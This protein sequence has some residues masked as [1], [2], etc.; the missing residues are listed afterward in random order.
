MLKS[1][2]RIP[3]VRSRL[4][5]V[6]SPVGDRDRLSGGNTHLDLLADFDPDLAQIAGAV[7]VFDRAAHKLEGLIDRHAGRHQLAQDGMGGLL[8]IRRHAVQLSVRFPLGG[9]C[10]VS[11]QESN[12]MDS[13]SPNRHLSAKLELL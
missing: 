3:G 5:C 9:G 6:D 12:G 7:I 11:A 4:A 2:E 1:I 10:S 13:T 8:R